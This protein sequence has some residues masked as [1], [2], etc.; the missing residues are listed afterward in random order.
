LLVPEFLP[1][2]QNFTLNFPA[3]D[4]NFPSE[5]F[6]DGSTAQT[7]GFHIKIFT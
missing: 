6:G 1:L 5:N 3:E 7:N 4:F 2:L